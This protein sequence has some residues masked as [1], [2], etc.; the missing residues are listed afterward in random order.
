MLVALGFGRHRGSDMSVLVFGG[1]ARLGKLEARGHQLRSKVIC[2]GFSVVLTCRVRICGFVYRSHVLCGGACGPNQSRRFD[3][4]CVSDLSLGEGAGLQS[5]SEAIN[6]HYGSFCVEVILLNRTLGK[7][8]STGS[9]VD[10][11]FDSSSSRVRRCP[12]QNV[13]VP[14]K[15][16]S[17][18]EEIKV[19]T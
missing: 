19:G 5:Q 3:Q 15:N 13:K 2:F 11:L 18:G 14:V 6:V 4:G 1:T 10:H 16:C 12:Y 8:H 9:G 7:P 17:I